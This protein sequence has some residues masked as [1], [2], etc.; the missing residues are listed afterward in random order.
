MA[1]SLAELSPWWLLLD[2]SVALR[3]TFSANQSIPL[4]AVADEEDNNDN[5]SWLAYSYCHFLSSVCSLHPF[6][7]SIIPTYWFTSTYQVVH[8]I[9]GC[10]CV[11]ATSLLKVGIV[12][13]HTFILLYIMDAGA[14]LMM[15]QVNF[16][17]RRVTK[18][19]YLSFVLVH[20]LSIGMV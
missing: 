9:Y 2:I 15:Q 13:I 14:Q 19:A 18:I 17:P 11:C 3:D 12:P 1:F 10:K 5:I 7:I 16:V 8:F 20:N 4:R 6:F